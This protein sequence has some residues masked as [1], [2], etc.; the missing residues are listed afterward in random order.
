MGLYFVEPTRHPA[1]MW[2]PVNLNVPQMAGLGSFFKKVAKTVSKVVHAPLKVIAP[3]LGKKLEALD[4]KVINKIDDIH[5]DINKFFK[6]NWKW[7][8]VAAAIVLTIYTMGAGST[9]VAKMA[10]GYAKLKTL[11]VAKVA[12]WKSSIYKVG[13]LAMEKLLGGAQMGQL[14]Q[15]EVDALGN[16]NATAGEAIIPPEVMATMTQGPGASGLATS[17]DGGVLATVAT[18]ASVAALPANQTPP[19][20]HA[21]ATAQA[22]PGLPPGPPKPLPPWVIPT[23]LGAGALVLVLALRR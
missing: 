5:T 9:L 3:S 11:V 13:G 6:R 10:S 16:M 15:Q 20:N 2:E 1:L 22:L 7:V 23:A 8:L 17:A 18:V 21:Q 19:Q 12:A 4:N 14:S